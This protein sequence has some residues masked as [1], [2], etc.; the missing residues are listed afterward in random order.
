MADE[1]DAEDD[2][3]DRDRAR[4]HA[5]ARA[6]AVEEARGA[7]E[8]HELDQAQRADR[9]QARELLGGGGGALRKGAFTRCFKAVRGACT[10][11]KSPSKAGGKSI[12]CTA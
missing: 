8:A 6:P 10:R 2:L 9:T 5:H 3:E 7:D 4:R 11:C 12:P 1:E